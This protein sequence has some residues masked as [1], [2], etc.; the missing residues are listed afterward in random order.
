M[1]FGE[2][3]KEILQ[4]IPE[5]YRGI[6]YALFGVAGVVLGATAVGFATAGVALPVWFQVATAV[7]T[8]LGGPVALTARV[9]LPSQ[10]P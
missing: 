9:N 2:E 6:F 5:K 7:Y 3:V 1:A 4:A 8:F 10:R